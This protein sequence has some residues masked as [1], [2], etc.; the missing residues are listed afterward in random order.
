MFFADECSSV[1]F[2]CLTVGL[3]ESFLYKKLSFGDDMT[4]IKTTVLNHQPKS[5]WN[6]IK[7]SNAK[8]LWLQWFPS[9]TNTTSRFSV[10]APKLY[11]RA[12]AKKSKGNIKLSQL[13]TLYPLGERCSQPSG[14][15]ILYPL[16]QRCN[17]PS[18]SHI[19]IYIYTYMYIYFCI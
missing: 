18:G 10:L 15:I 5:Y 4:R 9:K 2:T 3:L 17:Q 11:F 1:N 16:G 13:Y 8:L 19:H 7:S 14:S 12:N 6:A